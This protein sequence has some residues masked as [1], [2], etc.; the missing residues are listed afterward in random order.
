MQDLVTCVITPFLLSTT[1]GFLSPLF[2][3][4]LLEFYIIGIIQYSFVSASFVQRKDFDIHLR[5]YVSSPISFFVMIFLM[6]GF[7][8]FY[9]LELP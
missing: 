7:L 8:L 2:S 5:S 9:E 1:D 3:L 6:A 4:F